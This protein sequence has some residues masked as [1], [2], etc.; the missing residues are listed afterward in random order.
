[1]T[2]SMVA[3]VKGWVREEIAAAL[4]DVYARLQK[5]E[6]R[7]Q[8]ADKPAPAP[9]AKASYDKPASRP[10]TAAKAAP[11]QAKGTANK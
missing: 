8:Q 5:I 7:V 10:A 2:M 3:Q 4:A 1:M 6:E 9:A 11:A